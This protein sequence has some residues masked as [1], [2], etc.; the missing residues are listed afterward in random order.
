MT[1]HFIPTCNV[2]FLPKAPRGRSVP[3]AAAGAYCEPSLCSGY[4]EVPAPTQWWDQEDREAHVCHK[5]IAENER[6]Q[7][8]NAVMLHELERLSE[9]VGEADYDIVMAVIAEAEGKPA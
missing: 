2:C 3:D 6:L 5:C 4:M 7:E 8:I 9:L 1:N